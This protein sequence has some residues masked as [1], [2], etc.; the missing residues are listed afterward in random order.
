MMDEKLIELSNEF[1]ECL[2]DVGR[3]SKEYKELL[4]YVTDNNIKLDFASQIDP[5]EDTIMEDG[6][7][8]KYL[9]KI[10]TN[11]KKDDNHLSKCLEDMSIGIDYDINT[12]MIEYRT[13]SDLIL[14]LNNWNIDYTKKHKHAACYIDYFINKIDIGDTILLGSGVSDILYL[15]TIDS[16]CYFDNN[17][18][19]R[20]NLVDNIEYG[21]YHRRKITNIRPFPKN[22]KINKKFRSTII[23]L[24]EFEF[25]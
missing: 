9:I 12:S 11:G 15:V 1:S 6:L 18:D 4:D 17:P 5:I 7:D 16:E 24:H 25:I 23:R 20:S 8:A 2:N 10:I 21:L 22:T 13:K 14:G 19:F 3:L